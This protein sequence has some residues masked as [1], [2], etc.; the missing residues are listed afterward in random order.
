MGES[1]NGPGAKPTQPSKR[2]FIAAFVGNSVIAASKFGA[3]GFTG[4]S[5]MMAEGFH[6][7]VDATNNLLMLFGIR[8]SRRSPTP[9]HPFGYGKEL[10]FWTLIVAIVIFGIGGGIS[11]YE[12]VLHLLHP[13]ALGNPLWNYLVLAIAFIADGATLIIAYREFEPHQKRWGLWRGIR[14]SKDP[15]KFTVLLEDGAATTG[16]LLAVAGV[17][18][19]EATG[20]PQ[21]D[22]VASILIGL[23]LAAVAVLLS[24]E[25]RDLLV[26]E[27]ADGETLKAIRRTVETD[28]D[29]VA[30]RNLLTM[31]LGPS[32]LLLNLDVQFRDDLRFPEIAT[33]IERLESRLRERHSIVQKIFIEARNLVSPQTSGQT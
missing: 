3:A 10:Y 31:H 7:V 13:V 26:G 17:W 23:L 20:S 15:T 22:A 27:S 32:E 29:V 24:V 33:A 12:G 2:P 28:E 1:T 30:V 6:S 19:S 11:V 5:A 4:S 14:R 18:L 9:Q 25:S 8:G 16:I 21:Y